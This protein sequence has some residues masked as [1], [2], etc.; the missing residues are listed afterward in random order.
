MRVESGGG[1]GGGV[2]TEIEGDPGSIGE[3]GTWL[4]H[5][6]APAVD[7]AGDRA[8]DARRLAASGWTS[9][10]GD[11][12]AGTMRRAANA[13]DDLHGT[14]E[15]MAHDLR[16]FAAD[17]RRCQ[18]RM[19]D[20]RSTAKGKGLT[21]AGFVVQ[22][23]GPGPARPTMPSADASDAE[24]RAHNARVDAY[25]AHQD[26][27][28]AF[29]DAKDDAGRIDRQYSAA[30][31][32]LQHQYDAKDHAAYLL[33]LGDVLG[34]SGAA[35]AAAYLKAGRSKL[36]LKAQGL[37][38][39]AQ[40]A[41]DAMAAHPERYYSRRWIFFKKFDAAKY[42][43]DLDAIRSKASAADRLVREADNLKSSK[44][45]RGL[46]AGGKVLGAAGG[47][48]GVYS[49]VQD[50]ESVTQAVVSQG[51]GLAASIAAGAVI[52]T[53]IPVPVVGTVVGAIGGA[54]VGIAADGM[55]DSLFDNGPDV[56][57][58]LHEAGD[59]L[60]DTGGAIKDGVSSVG[61]AIGGLFD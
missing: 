21:V 36:L 6:L 4:G 5:T 31:E 56:G 57:A 17:L 42:S 27:V 59:A 50:G 51:G 40:R 38:Q 37:Y 53:A 30:C 52:G 13:A 54:I 46:G 61:S 32:S 33:T 25:D 8:N 18:E 3:A 60:A 16:D 28:R 26:L 15:G 35:G 45:P 12:F 48:L 58:A 23:P 47:I 14:V 2:D 11:G 34:E 43:G 22:D 44:L 7:T 10:A 41:A 24:V 49:D 19:A 55:I 39:E 20:V 1:G 29:N 9:D